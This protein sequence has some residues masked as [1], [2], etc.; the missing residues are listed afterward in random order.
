MTG[1]DAGVE[2][3]HRAL[4]SAFKLLS[5]HA[6]SFVLVSL[7]WSVAVLPVVTVGPATLGAYAA[8]RSLRN[9]GRVDRGEVLATLR[10]HWLNALLLGSVLV[11]TTA[12]SLLYFGRYVA[13]GSV[14]AGVL[15]VGGTYV[16]VHLGLIL[17][18][19]FIALTGGTDLFEAVKTSYRW[20]V[21]RPLVT[22]SILILTTLLLVASAVLSVAVVIVFPALAAAFHT[23]LL[24]P[25][26]EPDTQATPANEER[27]P[28]AGY[29]GF[30]DA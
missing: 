21:I 12:T 15:G 1:T 7:A 4:W 17:V 16:S 5:D 25:V 23:E 13:T 29:A 20:T 6:V 9:E 14:I 22:V 24:A 18:P 27:L 8:V 19:T 30:D 2:S 10:S 11:A 3:A 28:S 26:F